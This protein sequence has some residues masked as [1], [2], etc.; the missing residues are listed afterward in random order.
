MVLQSKSQLDE[1]KDFQFVQPIFCFLLQN[2]F[3]MC[4]LEISNVRCFRRYLPVNGRNRYMS[5]QFNVFIVLARCLLVRYR[6][7]RH[8]FN[9]FLFRTYS[10]PEASASPVPRRRRAIIGISTP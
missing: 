1:D 4:D 5:A 6:A 10:K 3:V 7:S 2:R 9:I 8:F